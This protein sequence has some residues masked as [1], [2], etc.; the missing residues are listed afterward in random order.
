MTVIVNGASVNYQKHGKGPLILWIHGWGDSLQTFAQLQADLPGYSHLSVDLPGF[1]GS[2]P[3]DEVYDLEAFAHFLASFLHKIDAPKPYAIIGHS[4][5][6][7]IAIK[8]LAGGL[9]RADK[10]ILLASSGVRSP[11]K[12][13]KKAL[14][15][16][17]KTAKLPTKA[18]PKRAQSAI[19]RKVYD[20]LGSDMLVAEHM[21]ESFKR[22]ISEDITHESAMI[23][24]PTLLIYGSQDHATPTGYGRLFARQIARSKLVV[25]EGAD[26]FLH[27]THALEV[28]RELDKFLRV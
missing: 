28:K 18:L 3:P 13:R 25:V 19:R 4:N 5:G 27:V 24:I 9:A 23:H 10:L 1:G 6:G 15:L 22:V 14:R 20:K 8:A 21:Q 12:G 26:H 2:D 16:L 11:Y 17:V 7:A